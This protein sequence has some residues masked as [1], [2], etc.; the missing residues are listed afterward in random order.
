[1]SQFRRHLHPTRR[2]GRLP[3]ARTKQAPPR[4]TA[5]CRA[6]RRQAGVHGVITRDAFCLLM[7]V[8]SEKLDAD[9]L[10][11]CQA[12]FDALDADGSGALDEADLADVERPRHKPTPP[13]G[14]SS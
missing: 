5:V 11:R 7:L 4:C 10:R 9:D 2:L 6:L 1:M 8:R 13:C 14:G 12:A 3:A